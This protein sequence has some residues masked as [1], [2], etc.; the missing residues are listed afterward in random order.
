MCI[1]DLKLLFML[2]CLHRVYSPVLQSE[3]SKM[4]STKQLHC[5]EE[6]EFSIGRLV[7]CMK[8]YLQPELR[9]GSN[10]QLEMKACSENTMSSIMSCTQTVFCALALYS[11]PEW[12]LNQTD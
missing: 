2:H 8:F 3:S 1:S 7:V 10:V 11:P 9:T 4:L 12:I 6:P 5:S